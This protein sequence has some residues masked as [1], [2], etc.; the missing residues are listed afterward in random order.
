MSNAL[1]DGFYVQLYLG[2]NKS[3]NENLPWGEFSKYP[4]SGGLFVG[5]GK[6][7]SRLWGW[8]AALRVNHNR[9][10]NV[11]SCESKEA[12]GWNNT[13]LFVDGTLDVSDVLRKNWVRTTRPRL[14]VKAFVGVG[15]AYTWMFDQVPLS[16]THAYSRSSRLLP[17]VRAGL[18]ATWRIAPK[19]RMGSEVSHTWFG[20]HFNG[21]AYGARADMR[22]NVKVGVTF[23]FVKNKKHSRPVVFKRKLKVCPALPMVTPDTEDVKKRQIVG[24]AFLDFPVNEMVI[25]PGYRNNPKELARIQATVDSAMFD[26][27]VVVTKISLHG[28]ASPESPYGNNT[29]LAKGR[30]ESLKNYLVKKYGFT[31]QLF[32]NSYSPEDWVNLRGFLNNMDG[33]RVKGDFW[34]DN[35]A[36]VETPE[37][38]EVMRVYREDLLR[39]IDMD[40]EP[41]AKEEV[42]KGVGHGVPYGWLLK[43]VYPGLRHTDYVI[44]Y[45]V[46]HYSVE[47][48]RK[49]IYTHPE[50]LSMNEMFLVAMSYEEGSAGWVDALLIAARQYPDDETANLN[51]ACACVKTKRFNDARSYLGKAGKGNE[52]VYLGHIIRAMEG[53]V[54]WNLVNGKVVVSER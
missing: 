21:V 2:M 27:S 24:R 35:Q 17:A 6:E 16:Y 10:R 9:S 32:C 8:R 1:K 37:V 20:D 49:L 43:H 38:P 44:E 18:T 13:G 15:M 11:Q 47:R 19:W 39:V 12:W 4:W 22:T 33:R 36:Y 28:Y 53:E 41:D 23:L 50:A 34:Y 7:L 5:V 40:L 31:E 42:L 26:E 48:C 45:E 25:Y 3:A 30:T 52:S 46:K 29:R 54:E 14:N 51:A